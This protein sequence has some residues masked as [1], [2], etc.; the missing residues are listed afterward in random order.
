MGS[1]CTNHFCSEAEPKIENKNN[2]WMNNLPNSMKI[3][4]MTIPGTHNSC[5]LYGTFLAQCQSWSITNQLNAG[6]RYFDLR[7]R[8]NEDKLQLQHGPI[9]QKIDFLEV[10]KLF[11][12]FLKENNSEFIIMS[13]QEEYKPIKKDKSFLELFNENIQ[14]YKDIIINFSFNQEIEYTLGE[15]R[16]KILFIEVFN[17]KI[18]RRTG[19]EVQNEWVCNYKANIIDKKRKVKRFFNKT[20]NLIKIKKLFINY[21]SASSDYLLVSPGEIAKNINKEV[22]KFKGRLGIVLCDFPGENLISY[23][24]EQNLNI[25]KTFISKNLVITNNACVVIKNFITGK[26]LSVKDNNLIC[27]KEP[28]NFVLIK[29]NYSNEEDMIISNDEITLMGDYN[30]NFVIAKN[31]S[32]YNKDEININIFNS[33]I[34]KLIN[35]NDLKYAICSDYEYKDKNKIQN[36]EIKYINNEI[37]Q[38]WIITIQN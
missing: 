25:E 20:I 38:N 7:L 30:F 4:L 37:N 34:I 16:G 27:C 36:V 5:A 31:F 17:G 26:Y 28:Y 8:L 23:L 14:E 15:L 12:D 29:K 18:Y 13:I 19:I 33:D 10:L 2:N 24:I 6:I 1:E 3:Y 9:Y 22:F 11:A 35:C 21:L 32:F